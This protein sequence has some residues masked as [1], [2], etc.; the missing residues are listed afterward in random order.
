MQGLS[1]TQL[2]T[3]AY[4]LAV[5]AE[6]GTAKYLIT[7]IYIVIEQ[8]MPDMLHVHPYLMRTA[9]FKITLDQ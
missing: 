9:C 4:K 5:F 6:I 2:E 3:V 8:H 1:R 7:T